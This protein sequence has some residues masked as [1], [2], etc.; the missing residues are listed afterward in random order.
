MRKLATLCRGDSGAGTPLV[1]GV[2]AIILGASCILLGAFRLGAASQHLAGAAD[3]AA[4]AAADVA[5]GRDPG[6]PCAVAE[7]VAG[8]NDTS[9]SV[10]E[11]R[12]AE[13]YVE[14]VT[15]IAGI[16]LRERAL[17]GPPRT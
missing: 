5:S 14:A 4:L 13:V 8:A 7:R 2:M 15:F 10:C 17:A 6:E 9:L 12:G 11:I 1:I 16:E 3:A